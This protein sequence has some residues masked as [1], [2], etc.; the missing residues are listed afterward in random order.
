MAENRAASR[1]QRG[2]ALITAVL[3]VALATILATRIGF[4]G[5]LEQRRSS[6]AMILEQAYLVGLGAEAWAASYLRK[7]LQLLVQVRYVNGVTPQPSAGELSS[8]INLE[9]NPAG[10]IRTNSD[11]LWDSDDELVLPAGN[12]VFNV[13]YC[14]FP[15]EVDLVGIMGSFNSRGR[16]FQIWLWDPETKTEGELL[17][18]TA[19]WLTPPI[20]T[21]DQWGGPKRAR[22]VKMVARSS[23]SARSSIASSGS[24]PAPMRCAMSR[25]LRCSSSRCSACATSTTCTLS[26][27][28][29][30]RRNAEGCASSARTPSRNAVSA[31]TARS[32]SPPKPSA[33]FQLARPSTG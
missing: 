20:V 11:L 29:L 18:D 14:D 17:Y 5:A 26:H 9:A 3:I 8:C 6:T 31:S 27:S 1:G 19:D 32:R 30:N 28:P 23:L 15:R 21:A 33:G 16:R 7:D 2:V 4:E 25:R 13:R 24:L 10:V 12:Q 22:A